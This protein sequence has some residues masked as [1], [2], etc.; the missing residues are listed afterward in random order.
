MNLRVR[1][2]DAALVIVD[3]QDRLLPA[4]PAEMLA[5]A[6]RNVMRLAAIA[7]LLKLPVCVSEQYPKGLGHTIPALREVLPSAEATYFTK[8]AFSL[9]DEPTFASFLDHGR[10]T[11][12]V[13]GMETHVCVYQSVR[14][15]AQRGY[16]V[17]VPADAV[18]S[19]TEGNRVV[20]LGL[21]ERSGAVVTST[22]TVLFDLV[23][24]AGTDDFR[25]LSRVVK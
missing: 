6:L 13:A 25:A 4:M 18:V 16:A 11:L 5:E 12:I 7:K 17:H 8:S 3:I 20:G 1:A 9:A 24:R 10:R 22:E 23:E 15:L 21:I 2:S 14:D 19:R